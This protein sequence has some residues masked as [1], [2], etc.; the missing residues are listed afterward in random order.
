MSEIS[1]IQAGLRCRCP[2]C[3]RGG[4]YRGYLDVVDRCAV[5]GLE[6]AR[7]DSGDGPAV[8]LIFILG[9]SVVPLALW[10]AFSVDWPLWAHAIL[11]SAVILGVTLGM[12]RPAK[13]F[14]L[15]LQYRHRRADFEAP[16][17]ER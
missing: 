17:A 2:R 3:G 6:L 11:W 9:F 10:L 15:A 13:A 12:L 5:C 16:A 1:P 8:F 4:L 7:N 14:V